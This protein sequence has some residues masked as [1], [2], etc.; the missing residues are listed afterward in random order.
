MDEKQEPDYKRLYID[1][2]SG[3]EKVRGL[4]NETIRHC[5]NQVGGD[6]YLEYLQTHGIVT[7]GGVDLTDETIK[8]YKESEERAYRL[9]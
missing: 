4:I 3:L 8:R 6:Y 1:A 5:K 2:L 7:H 9:D